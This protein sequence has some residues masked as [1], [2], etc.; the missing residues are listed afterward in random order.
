MEKAADVIEEIKQTVEDA[1]VDNATAVLEEKGEDVTPTTI[2]E[3]INNPTPKT[4][5][6]EL[7]L[8]TPEELGKKTM[9][10]DIREVPEEMID[11]VLEDPEKY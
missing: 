7:G 6:E 5:A 4:L 2:Q 9:T 10:L 11:K 8:V 3:E 1:Q